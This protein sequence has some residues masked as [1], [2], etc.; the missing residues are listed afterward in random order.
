[1]ANYAYLEKRINIAISDRPAGAYFSEVKDA[2]EAG[3][4]HF[5][6][7]ATVEE[8]RVN[9]LQNCIPDGIFDMDAG[10]YRDFLVQRRALMA[11]KI[12]DY[13]LGL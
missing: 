13:F 9:M 7:V 1:M 12:K 3:E 8:L 2:C 6:D 11:A 10:D 4:K 5:G